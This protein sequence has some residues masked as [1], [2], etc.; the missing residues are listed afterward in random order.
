MHC[1][2]LIWSLKG[3]K[4]FRVGIILSKKIERVKGNIF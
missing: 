3:G 2:K 1:F 4:N